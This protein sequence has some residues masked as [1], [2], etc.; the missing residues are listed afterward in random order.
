MVVC[1]YICYKNIN[2]LLPG[3]VFHEHFSAFMLS[4]ELFALDVVHIKEKT[5]QCSIMGEYLPFNSSDAGE[6]F[7]PVSLCLCE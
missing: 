5:E 4:L 1:N 2:D 6:T 7:A 3:S